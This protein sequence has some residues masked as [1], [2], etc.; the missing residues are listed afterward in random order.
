[1][2]IQIEVPSLTY[3]EL[4]STTVPSESSADIRARVIKARRFAEERFKKG[5]ESEGLYCNA[6]MGPAQIRKY[7]K[8]DDGASSLLEAAYKALGLSARGY[9]RIM[10]LARTIADL[11][12]SETI[13]AGHIA[14]AIR[15][16]ALD[17]KYTE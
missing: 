14:E 17:R 10:R 8:I 12:E 9:D 3:E 7:C 2:D 1:M 4:A 13:E 11:S 5:G 6:Q 15:L 16:R